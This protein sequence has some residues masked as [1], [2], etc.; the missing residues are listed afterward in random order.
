MI[1][2]QVKSSDSNSMKMTVTLC[3]TVMLMMVAYNIGATQ[4]MVTKPVTSLNTETNSEIERT[5]TANSDLSEDTDTNTNDYKIASD[6]SFGFFDDIPSEQWKLYQQIVSEYKPHRDPEDPYKDSKGGNTPAFY[7]TNYE[8]NFSCAFERRTGILGD[9]GKWVCDPHRLKRRMEKELGMSASESNKSVRKSDSASSSEKC[10]VYSVGSNGDF[11]FETALQHRLGNGKLCEVHI[12]DMGDFES[13]MPRDLNMHY[14]RWGLKMHAAGKTSSK[15]PLRPGKQYYSLAETVKLLGHENHRAIDIFKIDCEGCE[16]KTFQDWLEPSIPMI[17]QIL[18]E[19]HNDP[20]AAVPFFNELMNN[21]Y[22]MFHKEP[23]I[24]YG[25]GRCV[26]FGF[27]KLD[28]SF[29]DDV[30]NLKL[31]GK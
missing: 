7:Q 30:E 14:H 28:K 22:V 10:L 13:E 15:Y 3:C 18:V 31:A 25:G 4:S 27:L 29:Y 16:W 2:P 11:S 12:F 6:Q 17:Q 8:P 24:Q 19:T 20:P 23:N 9:G 1:I 26:E 5:S 21:G